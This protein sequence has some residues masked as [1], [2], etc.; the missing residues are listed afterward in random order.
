[1][2]KK[3]MRSPINY[4]GGKGNFVSKLLPLIPDH[5]AYAEVFGGG[6]S[7]L[8][9]KEQVYSEIYND[10]DSTLTDFF[11]LL[12]NP[13]QFDEFYQ[14]CLI[15]PYS[16]ELWREFR[17]TWQLQ[18]NIVDRIHQWFSVA[19][20]SFSG[21]FG[22]SWS[23]GIARNGASKF[24]K[25]VDGLPEVAQRLRNVQIDNR[26]W[27]D[28]LERYDREETFFYLDPP[29][30]HS[31]RRG[32]DFSFEMNDAG[33][34]K[35]VDILK[36]IKGR[37]L[38]SGYPNEI[39]NG[40]NWKRIDHEVLCYAVGKTKATGLLGDGNVKGKQSRTESLWLNYDV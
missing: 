2:I 1:M 16:K 9:A 27:D 21:C 26:S 22:A 24:R 20:M 4:F 12:Q 33:H 3:K 35:L 38:L 40:L 36:N 23:F 17:D 13:V 6:A 25:A 32:G 18:D 10:I 30:V 14:K 19:R 7:L 34:K 31:T 37:V 5:K 28:A 29:Y 39:Y 15:T 8:F 11:R